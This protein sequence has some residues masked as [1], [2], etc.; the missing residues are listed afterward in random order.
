MKLLTT[1]K[2]VLPWE[3]RTL[4]P[5]LNHNYREQKYMRSELENG[6]R[7]AYEISARNLFQFYES[8]WKLSWISINT[9]SFETYLRKKQH[10]LSWLNKFFE[11]LVSAY[12]YYYYMDN[13]KQNHRDFELLSS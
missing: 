9:K 4:V 12:Y 5:L 3:Q 13:M 6:A 11:I 8:T 2:L 1:H 10:I 7:M